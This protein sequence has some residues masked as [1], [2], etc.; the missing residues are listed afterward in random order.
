MSARGINS[1]T[2]ADTLKVTKPTVS[3]WINGKVF[4]PPERLE[5]IAEVL[6]VEVWEL[7]KDPTKA[8]ASSHASNCV[9]PY[10][11]HPLTIRVE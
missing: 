3:Y 1:V 7:F 5:S 4:P 8:V 9:C 6:G 10:C 11:G 2:L